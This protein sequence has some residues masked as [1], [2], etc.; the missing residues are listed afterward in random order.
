MQTLLT[1]KNQSIKRE[2]RAR[3][4]TS[5]L[6][7]MKKKIISFIC[8]VLFVGAVAFN[9][10]TLNSND[11]TNELV[12]ENVEALASMSDCDGDYCSNFHCEAC[13]S[14]GE[15]YCNLLECGCD[16]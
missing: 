7:K 12:L 16:K 1:N 11:Q 14:D 15:A 8:L 5:N 13:C 10:Q 6:Q 2:H 9:I 3:Y 4:R